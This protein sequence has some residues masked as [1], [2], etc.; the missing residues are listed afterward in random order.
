MAQKSGGG[1]TD[2]FFVTEHEYILSYRRTDAFKWLD[3]NE[4]ADERKF[5]YD[6]NDGKGKYGITKLENGEVQLIAKI[7]LQCVFQ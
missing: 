5:K 4:E 1:Q 2:E 3:F 7:D 6:D